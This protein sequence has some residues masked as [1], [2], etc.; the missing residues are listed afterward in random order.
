MATLSLDLV[1]E[2]LCRLPVKSLKRFRAVAKTWGNLIDSENFIKKHLRQS[3]ITTSHRYLFLG[4]AQAFIVQLEALDRAHSISPPYYDRAVA[5]V[6]NSCNGIML[7]QCDPPVLWNA[8]SR[9]YR[10]LP[11]ILRDPDEV[12]GEDTYGFGYV[13]ESDD[14]KVVRVTESW[15]KETQDWVPLKTNVYSL[16]SNSWRRIEN[17]SYP[18]GHWRVH[19]N[20]ALHTLLINRE[21]VNGVI[22]AFDL[23]SEE[24]FEIMLPPGIQITGFHIKLIVLDGCLCVTCT[25]RDTVVIWVMEEYGVTESWVKLFIVSTEEIDCVEPLTYSRDG[26]RVLVWCD[27]KWFCWCDL[28]S[29]TVEEIDVQGLDDRSDAFDY[30]QVCVESLVKLGDAVAEVSST[31]MFY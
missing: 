26:A 1:E 3:L 23:R 21:E 18:W 22:M 27:L 25:G 15:C 30:I 16:R 29:N 9:E 17:F 4:G 28:S 5:G 8:F 11:N 14:Y 19:L 7:V 31:K 12:K 24:H 6:S 2:I 20:G 10:I 13:S